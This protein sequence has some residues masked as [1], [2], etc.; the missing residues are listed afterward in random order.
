MDTQNIHVKFEDS[1]I[2]FNGYTLAPQRGEL[3]KDGAAV[4]IEPQLLSFLLLLIRQKQNLEHPIVTR[5]IMVNEIWQGKSVSDDAVRAVVKKLREVLADDAR[6]PTFIRTIPTKGYLLVCDVEIVSIGPTLWKKRIVKYGGFTSIIVAI[7]ILI[8]TL[9]LWLGSED[10]VSSQAAT[11]TQISQNIGIGV[12]T[13]LHKNGL[14]SFI[15]RP[16]SENSLQLYVKNLDSGQVRR[17]SWAEQNEIHA[18]WNPD[19]DKVFIT[20]VIKDNDIAH[21]LFGLKETGIVILEYELEQINNLLTSNPHFEVISWA[22]GDNALYIFNKFPNAQDGSGSINRFNI[23]SGNFEQILVLKNNTDSIIDVKD[24]NSSNLLAILYKANTAKTASLIIYDMLEQKIMHDVALPITS[25]NIIWS[26]DG[27]RLSFANGIGELWSYYVADQ[28]LLK[29]SGLVRNVRDLVSDCGQTCFIFTEHNGDYLDVEEVPLPFSKR[30][31]LSTQ[32]ITSD[33]VDT[34]P[35]YN[36]LDE[37]YFVSTSQTKSVINSLSSG[38]QIKQIFE[39]PTNGAVSS[40]AIN[41][42]GTALIG[43]IDQRIFLYRL[44]TKVFSFVTSV[45]DNASLPNWLRSGNAFTY[46][47]QHKQSNELQQTLLPELF[48]YELQSSSRKKLAN[49]YN[50]IQTID[51]NKYVL[52]D[53]QGNISYVEANSIDDAVNEEVLIKR[54]VVPEHVLPTL[55]TNRWKLINSDL[56]YSEEKD[57]QMYLT[58]LNL[59]NFE[60]ESVRMPSTKNLAE[61]DI[62]SDLSKLLLVK[63]KETQHKLIKVEGLWIE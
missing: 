19:A 29:W 10:E 57:E 7:T 30:D 50:A 37:I 4:K 39:L 1:I 49:G 46:V 9:Y 24:S 58:K 21:S 23:N 25:K 35:V 14:I 62:S 54:V 43:E 52:V 15:D 53:Q 48:H 60:Y 45:K 3:S 12:S 5:E 22:S 16:D 34:L 18:D 27:Q 36:H 56:Y 20:R 11:F 31:F 28:R 26:A 55:H 32:I 59:D 61:F 47:A 41:K 44:D 6:K 2:H 42:N 17:I 38:E 13:N 51:E 33:Q 63:N 40:L 8:Q